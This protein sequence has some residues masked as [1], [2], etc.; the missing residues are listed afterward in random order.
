V[1]EP[2]EIVYTAPKGYSNHIDHWAYFADSIRNGTALLEDS[3][4]GLRA[5][6]PSLA[7][8]D[9]LFEKK[10]IHWD[11]IGMKKV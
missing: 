4:F 1:Q 8:N 5:A 3:A 7:T 10:I 6:G 11:P 9:S 2:E